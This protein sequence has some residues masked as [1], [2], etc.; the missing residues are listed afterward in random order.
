MY[1][2]Q[3]HRQAYNISIEIKMAVQCL[4]NSQ[5]VKRKQNLR[6]SYRAVPCAHKVV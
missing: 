1:I 6:S 5:N 3:G 4:E 2:L